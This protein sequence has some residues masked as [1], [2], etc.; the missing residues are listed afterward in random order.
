MR[1]VVFPAHRWRKLSLVRLTR[2]QIFA[3]SY[4]LPSVSN[5]SSLSIFVIVLSITVGCVTRVGLVA[6]HI[7]WIRFVTM[8]SSKSKSLPPAGRRQPLCSKCRRPCRGHV[9]PPGRNCSMPVDVLPQPD[10]STPGHVEQKTDNV[11][12]RDT[13]LEELS[14]Q[15]G[16]MSVNMQQMQ[17]DMAAM[18]VNKDAGAISGA[19]TPSIPVLKSPGYVEESK[20]DS[21]ECLSS[22]A[23]VTTKVLKSARSGE[24][25][26]LVDFAPVLEPTNVT[27]TS[28]VDGELTFKQKRAV[29]SLDS[30]L[31]WSLAWR[32][33]V[34]HLVEGDPTLYKKLVEYRIFI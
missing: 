17:K 18:N 12:K 26:N 25:I 10:F 24:C 14:N 20:G 2:G 22:G 21:Y 11:S 32:G 16:I 31:L 34:E 5:V 9:G 30:F 6:A 33:Y 15:V 8:K 3:G 4:Q 13:V 28:L 7:F 29:H 19:G 1:V 27:E 23:K